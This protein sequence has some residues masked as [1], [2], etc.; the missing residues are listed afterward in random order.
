MP[1][2]TQRQPINQEAMKLPVIEFN[3]ELHTY[4]VDGVLTPSV[5]QVINMLQDFSFVPDDLLERASQFGR[6]VHKAVELYVLGDLNESKLSEPLVPYLNQYKKFEAET[7]FVASHTEQPVYSK[8][9]YCGTFDLAGKL[10]GNRNP[11]LI[12]VKSCTSLH[13]VV[14]L[15]LAAYQQAFKETCG[16][17]TKQRFALKLTDKNYRLVEY[18]DPADF[19]IFNSCLKLHNWRINK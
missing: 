2:W 4:L 17:I 10:S 8:F 7:G 14:G 18:N 6:A 11:V 9:G 16:I 1:N 5:T 15:Q 12:D 19:D 3:E 13:K